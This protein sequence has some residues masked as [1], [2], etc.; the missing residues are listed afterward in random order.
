VL[1][2]EPPIETEVPAL[3]EEVPPLLL[4]FPPWE[5][6]PPCE[7]PSELSSVEMPSLPEVVA[8]CPV[9]PES[10]VPVW[11]W[12]EPDKIEPAEELVLVPQAQ[13]VTP[14]NAVITYLNIS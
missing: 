1:V 7:V 9:E 3:E 10:L 14:A 11:E 4:E 5:L 8:G 6:F 2:I 12:T 13:R